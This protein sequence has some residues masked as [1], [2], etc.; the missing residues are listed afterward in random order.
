MRINKKLYNYIDYE[1][2]NYKE[3]AKAIEN[4][5]K[6]I[7]ESSPPPSDG[8]PTAKNRVTDPTLDKVI[9]ITTPMAIYRM[10]FNKRCIEK[11]LSKLDSYHNE[12]FEKNY[13]ENNGNNKIGVCYE[14]HISERTYYRMKNKVIE[15]VA[16]EMGII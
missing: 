9:Q 5:K 16:R 4:M 10:E 2:T 13:K 14:M 3:Y 11:A 8:Q 12:F 7:I 6:D 15:Y 1:L